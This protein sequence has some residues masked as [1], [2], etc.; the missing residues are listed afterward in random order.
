MKP[1]NV[2]CKT[3]KVVDHN[4]N[5]V[6]TAVPLVNQWILSGSHE[7]VTFDI[8]KKLERKLESYRYSP[9]C[10]DTEYQVLDKLH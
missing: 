7:N 5:S 9:R 2:E 8:I 4:F 1:A 10:F 6:L 3:G